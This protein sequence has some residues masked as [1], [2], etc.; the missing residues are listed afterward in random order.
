MFYIKTRKVFTVYIIMFISL[1]FRFGSLKSTKLFIYN[2]FLIKYNTKDDT[3]GY[4]NKKNFIKSIEH[5][6]I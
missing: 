4:K 6:I 5:N 3:F 2:T 1:E